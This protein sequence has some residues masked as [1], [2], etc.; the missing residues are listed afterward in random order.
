MHEMNN[1][2]QKLIENGIAVLQELDN[3]TKYKGVCEKE[4]NSQVEKYYAELRW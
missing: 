2:L 3:I 4:S 1:C